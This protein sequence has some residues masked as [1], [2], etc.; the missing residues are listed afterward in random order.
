MRVPT[1]SSYGEYS[2]RGYG[3]H[4]LVVDLGH[5]VLWFSYETC[6]AF[7]TPREG[8]VVR[9]NTWGPTTGRHLNWIDGGDKKNRVDSKTFERLY[10]ERVEGWIQAQG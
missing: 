9:E 3:A 6:V 5:A 7:C 4:S 8:L 2:S 10:A 1:I